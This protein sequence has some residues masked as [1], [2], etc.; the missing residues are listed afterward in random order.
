[1][2]E[3]QPNV[4]AV[5]GS[6]KS[7]SVTRVV[8]HHLAEKFSA[9]GCAVDILDLAAEPLDMFNPETTKKSA[10]YPALQARVDKADVFIIGSPDYHGSISSPIKNFLDYFWSEFTGK[11][12]VPVVASH[13]K[14][15]TV[16]EQIRT[17]ARQCYAW[18][19][20][21]GVSAADKVDVLDGRVASKYMLDRLDMVARDA[22]V[23]GALIARQRKED[24]A[25]EDCSF[26]AKHRKR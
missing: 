3:G 8:I 2:S 14:G 21:Y 23:Y 7:Q 6:L 17:I 10:S 1:M 22:R 15:L 5:V 12:F 13:E 24:L 16:I 18:T 26:L 25:C 11:L 19:L 4:L 9:A 20:P